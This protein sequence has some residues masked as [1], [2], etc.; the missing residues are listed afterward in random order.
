MVTSVSFYSFKLF[1]M[2]FLLFGL[3]AATAILAL[4]TARRVRNLMTPAT[5]P[6]R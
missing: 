5:V 4:E 3:I 6:A 1:V 2:W